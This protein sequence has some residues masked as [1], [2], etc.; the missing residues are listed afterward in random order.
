MSPKTKLLLFLLLVQGFSWG[1]NQKF[2]LDQ[3]RAYGVENRKSMTIADLEILSAQKKVLEVTAMGLPQINAEGTFQ[4]Y[5]NIPTT[6]VDATFLDPTAP[7]G[8]T[9]SFRMGTKYSMIGGISASQ[10]LFDGSYFVGLQVSKHVAEFVAMNK[11]Q[12][13]WDIQYQVT[14]AYFNVLTAKANVE[15]LDSIVKS[16]ETLFRKMETMRSIG[17]I[18]QQEVDQLEMNFSRSKA[19]LNNANRM[20]KVSKNLLKMHMGYP[21]EQDIEVDSNLSNYM[22]KMILE[23]GQLKG[24]VEQNIQIIL[25]AKRKEIAEYE[26]K[27]TQ[28]AH[29][30]QLSTFF[31]HQYMAFRNEFNFFSNGDWF[32][33]T[34]WGVNLRV[35]IFSGGMRHQR[36]QQAKIDVMKREEEINE[37]KRMLQF[38]EIRLIQDFESAIDQLRIEEKNVELAYKIY[39]NVSTKRNIGT[40]STLDVT[41]AYSQVLN[42]Q[43]EYIRV[44]ANLLNTKNELDNLYGSY[45]KIIESK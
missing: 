32:P 33:S 29:F 14:Q 7:P 15:I 45:N 5:I 12:V 4:Q 3:A 10:L 30:P 25:L 8:A 13:A 44:C 19:M 26:L 41:Q 40:T 1:Q 31:N 35:P 37:T 21:Y 6:V 2:S 23:Y 42:A 18:E 43:A 27:N 11:D 34:A 17:F 9:T 38:Q 24:S 28:Y 36:V 16:T 20:L 39:S 22:N